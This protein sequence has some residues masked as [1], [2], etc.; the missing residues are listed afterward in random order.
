MEKQHL[1]YD[2]KHICPFN[3]GA[4]ATNMHPERYLL[5]LI[6]NRKIRP[7]LTEQSIS[8]A[9]NKL[10]GETGCPAGT[11]PKKQSAQVKV[12]VCCS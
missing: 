10:E 3:Y 4:S 11:K 7:E 1:C 8:K 12:Y 6:T 2:F 9:T 5:N